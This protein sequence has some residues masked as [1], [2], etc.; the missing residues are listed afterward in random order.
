M[1]RRRLTFGAGVG[2]LILAGLVGLSLTA[3]SVVA[4]LADESVLEVK[5]AE[6]PPEPEPEPA[7]EPEPPPTPVAL[8]PRQV[9]LPS[10]APP[11]ELSDAPLTE[12]EP[13]DANPNE[14]DPYANGVVSSGAQS[15]PVVKV[16]EKPIALKPKP[17][18]PMR[19][20]ENVTPPK[21]LSQVSPGYP[22]EAKQAGLEGVVIIKYVVT[23]LGTVTGVQV[24]RG[25]AELRQVCIEALSK[26]T[27]EPAV[28]EGRAVAVFRI[29]RFPFRITT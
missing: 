11:T 29:A 20:T 7:P 27:F 18:G 24:L 25:P 5:L 28:F 14:G 2:A 17:S 6:A 4:E 23:E 3:K 12:A 9:A 15:A 8:V 13:T 16:A 10:L 1:R 26:W 21:V 22:A 19:V